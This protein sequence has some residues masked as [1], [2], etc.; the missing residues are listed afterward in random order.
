MPEAGKIVG[1]SEKLSKIF[2]WAAH[3]LDE[4][5]EPKL[6]LALASNASL[7][8]LRGLASMYD[9]AVSDAT[10]CS[11][12]LK[13]ALESLVSLTAGREVVQAILLRQSTIRQLKS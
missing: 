8:T 7:I 5:N 12:I 9:K 10:T 4:Y 11:G 2:G 3:N 1:G 6:M 13:L